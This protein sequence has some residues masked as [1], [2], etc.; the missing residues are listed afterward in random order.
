MVQT[1]HLILDA[2][3]TLERLQNFK[4]LKEKKMRK[5]NETHSFF[6]LVKKGVYV[7]FWRCCTACRFLVP[8]PGIKPW[9]PAV[10]TQSLNH[11]T[12]REGPVSQ[13]F[14]KIAS[15]G[16]TPRQTSLPDHPSQEPPVRVKAQP[17]DSNS[18]GSSSLLCRM[19]TG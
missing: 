7:Y 12:T 17:L 15:S 19:T 11:W 16:S 13:F 10:E 14:S 18:S 2:K 6:F 4:C 9:P 8:Q 3:K 1:R 5:V